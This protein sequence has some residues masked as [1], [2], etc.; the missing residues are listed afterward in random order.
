MQSSCLAVVVWKADVFK[1][2]VSSILQLQAPKEK[3]STIEIEVCDKL[4]VIDIN[5]PQYL[6]MNEISISIEKTSNIPKKKPKD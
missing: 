1:S 5:S 2:D 3:I 4:H 6:E